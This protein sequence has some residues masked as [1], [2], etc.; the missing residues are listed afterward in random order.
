MRT[1]RLVGVAAAGI[2]L[3]AAC[4]EAIREELPTLPS[5]TPAPLIPI[6]PVGAAPQLGPRPAPGL[7]GQPGT[8]G[9]DEEPLPAQPPGG[10]GGVSGTCSDPAP[11]PATRVDVKVH[12]AG[13]SRLVLDATV[14]VGP[15]D[16]YCR[17]IGFTD[18]RRF[19]PPRPEGHPERFACDA[20][21]AGR[22]ADT[23]RAGPTWRVNGGACVFSSGCE[24]HPD[25]QFL[26]F[27]Y[28]PGTYQACVAS[29]VCGAHVVP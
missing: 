19:C 27:A 20:A 13:A 2:A 8:P 10:D 9:G 7:P 14:L 28:G 24:N 11:G 25:N 4:H 16:A 12:I 21:L 23:G 1:G 15:D 17:L 29:G 6:V 26:A 5:A 3:A 22:A 18:G